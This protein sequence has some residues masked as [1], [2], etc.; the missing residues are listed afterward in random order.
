MLCA[1]VFIFTSGSSA[2][3]GRPC[4]G[5]SIWLS[6]LAIFITLFW[7][8]VNFFFHEKT[9]KTWNVWCENHRRHLLGTQSINGERGSLSTFGSTPNH[10]DQST[11]FNLTFLFPPDQS[12]WETDSK[13]L[14]GHSDYSKKL[15]EYLKPVERSG[16]K[17]TRCYRASE[18]S[19][20]AYSFHSACNYKGPTVV[21]VQ[22]G[23]YVFGGYTDKNW[24]GEYSGNLQ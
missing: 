5:L 21:L 17:W 4:C 3:L 18:S 22:V 13:I 10:P 12:V 9:D 2:L 8:Y 14:K 15:S 6:L 11:N 23:N 19:Y 20:S 24:G 16:K 7:V 1:P